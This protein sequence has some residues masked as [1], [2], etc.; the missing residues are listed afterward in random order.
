MDKWVIVAGG[1]LV[2]FGVLMAMGLLAA[3]VVRVLQPLS[4]RVGALSVR[5]I[6][7]GVGAMLVGD[8]FREGWV[9]EL[10]AFVAFVGI[11]LFV[12]GL[13]KLLRD[14]WD[15]GERRKRQSETIVELSPAARFSQWMGEWA[16]HDRRSA[17]KYRPEELA[18]N[19]RQARG[20]G[21]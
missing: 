3:G 10:A 9:G 8:R 13:V 21:S 19:L 18:E 4:G 15:W 1:Y 6:L 17:R 16:A 14:V 11:L 2:F 5:L 20:R 7:A 12:A